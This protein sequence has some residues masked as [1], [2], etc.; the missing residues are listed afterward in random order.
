MLYLAVLG[1][2]GHNFSVKKHIQNYETRVLNRPEFGKLRKV[3]VEKWGYVGLRES[4][5]FHARQHVRLWSGCGVVTEEVLMTEILPELSKDL[6][7]SKPQWEDVIV[8][9]FVY[10]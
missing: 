7:D 2:N 3:W 1:D 6:D 5:N 4:P 9:N 8:R 10:R